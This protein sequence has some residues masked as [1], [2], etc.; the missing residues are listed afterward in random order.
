M[1]ELDEMSDEIISTT[2]QEY[3]QKIFE[4]ESIIARCKEVMETNDPMNFKLIFGEMK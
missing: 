1:I 2:M 3:T 4:L